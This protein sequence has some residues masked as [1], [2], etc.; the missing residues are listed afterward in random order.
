MA[1]MKTNA[2][3]PERLKR[4]LAHANR[5]HPGFWRAMDS[6]RS[7]RENGLPSWA[8]WCYVPIHAAFA[9]LT[10]GLKTA[11]VLPKRRELSRDLQ[12]GA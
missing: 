3:T 4:H 9:Y 10:P 7:M 5:N 1:T 8:D 2:S 11:C 6:A 12:R